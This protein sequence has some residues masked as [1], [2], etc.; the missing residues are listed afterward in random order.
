MH[1][2]KTDARNMPEYPTP[3]YAGGGTSYLESRSTQDR[4]GMT[5]NAFIT[6]AVDSTFCDSEDG[7]LVSSS[8]RGSTVEYSRNPRVT[9]DFSD[10]SA[11]DFSRLEVPN[12]HMGGWRGESRTGASVTPSRG[13]SGFIQR[14]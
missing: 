9:R 5:N 10:G 4:L 1:T 12:A 13:Y 8:V 2:H 14:R 11:K 6:D 7:Y 3:D